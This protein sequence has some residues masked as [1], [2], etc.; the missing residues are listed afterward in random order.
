MRHDSEAVTV[1]GAGDGELMIRCVFLL[2]LLL[3]TLAPPTPPPLKNKK[4]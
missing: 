4:E 2:P 3:L 1:A